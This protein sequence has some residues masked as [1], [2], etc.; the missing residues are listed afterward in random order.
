MSH[1]SRTEVLRASDA[2]RAE[3]A[4][5][6][7]HLAGCAACRSRAAS[8]LRDR[9]HQATREVP[10]R[11]LLELATFEMD[12]AVAQLLAR[13]ELAELRRLTRG[14]QKERVIRSRSCHSPAFLDVILASLRAQQAREEA[15]ALASLAVL[16]AQGM[17]SRDGEAFK[18][19]LLATI[20]TET[21][22]ARRIN[23]DW[24]HAQAAL[25]R[26]GEYLNLGTGNPSIRARWL[27]ITASLRTDQCARDEAMAYLEE[28]REI[29]EAQSDWP[30]VA[31]TLVQMAHCIADKDPAR[32]LAVLDRA[33]A[34]MPSEDATLR[35]LAVSIR[36]E[37]LI[38]LGRV[39]EA[40]QAF[41]D[42][43]LL[44]PLHF[45]AS[46]SLKSA[47]TAARL[48]EALGR[49][50]EAEALFLEAI[51]GDIEQGRYKDALLDLLYAFGFHVRQGAP[52]RAVELS[53][54]AFDEMERQDAVVHEQLHVLWAQ[55]IDA[56]RAEDLDDGMLAEARAY[57]EMHWRHP[58][59]EEPTLA[60]A[61]RP[62]SSLQRE[63]AAE[64]AALIEPLLARSLWSRI[65]QK[66]RKEQ[67]RQVADSPECHTRAFFEVLLADMRAAGSRDESEF[68]ASLALAA[69]EPAEEV[70]PV[71]CDLKA[72]AWIEIANVCR[73]DAEWNRAAAALRRAH[74]Q[75]A[76]GSG[77]LLA[78][79]RTQSVAA[80]LR[81]DQGQRAEAFA[82][83]E[84][85]LT[86]YEG[87]RAW[88]LV[89]RTLVQ[90]A[91]TLVDTEPE[92]GFALVERALPM[93]PAADAA[94]RW[95][96]ESNRTECLI[97]MKEI[98]P[99]L[100]AFHLAESLRASQPRADAER[101]STFTA[102][103]LL[104]GLGYFK[105]AECL[106]QTA[107]T[108]AFER[109]AYR[110]GCLDLLYLYGLHIRM[111]ETEKAMA[112]CRYAVTKLDLFRV[113]HEQL[114]TVWLD[115]M[116]AARCSIHFES[117]AEVRVY[118]EVH[119]KKPAARTPYISH[120]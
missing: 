43:E 48:L 114:R 71:K 94:L 33:I 95:L 18:N 30:L 11:T 37:C 15:E 29:Y 101:Q 116:T 104:E 28:C 73:I 109:E 86:L 112:L 117:L 115:L 36:A 120:G 102:A 42:A 63:A 2:G 70:D 98:G 34:F 84:E 8:L 61:K 76:R 35:W 45:R 50:L 99:A 75:L 82:M 97:G 27:S 68:I 105:E 119:W 31:R 5:L 32:G 113:G 4:R 56:A 77:D 49:P 80:S 110:E 93:I 46:A 89:A 10:L 103:R 85:C 21:A 40:L 14:A 108:D 51:M 7:T 47:F 78:R 65:R 60:Q 23:G 72:L 9:A 41:H 52:E 74:E 79:A 64:G 66:T 118:F 6:A 100:Q 81:A 3:I 57:L 88:P 67:Q 69:I 96:A 62:S 53:L 16:A 58:A 44:R 111:G 19:D 24:H 83:L 22:N 59:S 106:F 39:G 12:A 87:E 13:A 1:V 38:D 17:D 20:W 90:M 54:R 107:I 55:L 91:H 25:R 26:A 92:R